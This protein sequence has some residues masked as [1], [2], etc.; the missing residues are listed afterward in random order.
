M[1]D[2]GDWLVHPRNRVSQRIDR[3]SNRGLVR[4]EKCSDDGRCTF[5]VLVDNGF[6]LIERAAP[7]HVLVVRESV[8][9]LLSPEHL[10]SGI[11]TFDRIHPPKPL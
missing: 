5:A 1:S 8:I 10:R 6:A 3:M 9:D 4:R 7:D 11:E 2:L